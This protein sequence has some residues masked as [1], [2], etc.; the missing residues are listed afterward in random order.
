MVTLPRISIDTRNIDMCFGCGRN[1]PIGLKLNLQRHGKTVRVEFTPSKLHQ[2]WSDVVHGG[3][4]YCLLDEA[5]SYTAIFE[6]FNCVTAKMEA[7]LKRPASIGELLIITASMTRNTRRLVNAKANISLKDGTPIAEGTA[8]MFVI[9]KR[10]DK[11][12]SNA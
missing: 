11:P 7:R 9:S 8:T 10:E 4:I 12:K 5:M 1:N 2:G 3:I 6:G